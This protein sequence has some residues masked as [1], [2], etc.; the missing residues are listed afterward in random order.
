MKVS[1]FILNVTSEQPERLKA[2]YR[3]TVQLEPNPHMGEERV[4]SRRRRVVCHRRPQRDDRA[5][6]RSRSAR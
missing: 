5:R 3:D 1:S 6:P 2:F 4:Q